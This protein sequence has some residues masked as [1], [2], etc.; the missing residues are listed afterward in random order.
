MNALI[1]DLLLQLLNIQFKW[2]PTWEN[3]RKFI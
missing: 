3:V 1:R 2:N